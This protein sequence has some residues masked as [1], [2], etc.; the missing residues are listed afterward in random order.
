MP[1]EK[2]K[3][4]LHLILKIVVLAYLILGILKGMIM[5]SAT[6]HQMAMYDWREA[7]RKTFL[8]GE[9]REQWLKL[10]KFWEKHVKKEGFLPVYGT[11][12]QGDL[13]DSAEWLEE[14]PKEFPEYRNI[15]YYAIVSSGLF[16]PLDLYNK[17]D[18]LTIENR[19]QMFKTLLPHH[20]AFVTGGYQRT[21]VNSPLSV[22]IHQ[23]TMFFTRGAISIFSSL[24][25]QHPFWSGLSI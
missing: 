2:M 5:I 23:V 10:D 25:W 1:T 11:S 4:A 19:L 18:S 14:F 13:T 15:F 20:V 6:Y 12:S 9:E 21:P 24:L 7:A 8:I 22:F 16:T 3:Q 17:D